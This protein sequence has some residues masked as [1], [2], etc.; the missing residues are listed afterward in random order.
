M[1]TRVAIVGTG[2]GATVHIPAFSRLD[3]VKIV[4]VVSSRLEKAQAIAREHGIACAMDD[5]DA[6]LDETSPDLVTIATPPYLHRE[7]ALKAIDRGI[8]VLCEKPLALNASEAREMV[9]AAREKGIVHAVCHE[10]RYYPARLEFLNRLR[11]GEIGAVHQMQIQ[12]N[13]VL[14]PDGQPGPYDWWSDVERGGGILGAV[15]SHYID[16]LHWWFGRIVEVSSALVARVPLRPDASTGELRK[17]TSDDSSAILLRMESGLV[18][19]LN[20]TAVAGIRGSRIEAHGSKGSLVIEND[21]RLLAG[22][23]GGVLR[24]IDLPELKHPLRPGDWPMMGAFTEL[25]ARVI[26]R[27]NGSKEDCFPDFQDGLE[28][29]LVLDAIRRASQL[30]RWVALSPDVS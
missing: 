4:A 19:S 2:F 7:M 26:A 8:H 21:E 23:V 30:Q 6:M 18:A 28:V 14:G 22:P 29:Q 17:V 20:L 15:G 11:S 1:T 25:A 10:F 16:C 5:Y 3:G 9:L 12:W 27:I 13:G 24:P